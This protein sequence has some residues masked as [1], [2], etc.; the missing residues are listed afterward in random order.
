MRRCFL[1]RDIAWQNHNRH[2]L[3]RDGGLYRNLECARHL[4]GLR[5]QLAIMATI[6]KQPFWMGLLEII[7]ADLVTRNMRSNGQD[8]HTTSMAVIQPIDQMQITWA[9]TPGAYR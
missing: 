6:Q 2:S 7:A 4:G 3:T 8:R 9:A 5:D 1:K